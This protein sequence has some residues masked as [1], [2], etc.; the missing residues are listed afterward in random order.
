[1]LDIHTHHPAPQPSGVISLR[2]GV[3]PVD[4]LLPGQAYSAGI[5]PWDSL[6]PPTPEIL[7]ILRETVARPEI[8]A[9]GE[10]GV[11]TVSGGPMFRQ[12][13]L[14]RTHVEVSEEY[15]KPLVIHDVKAHDVVIGLRRDLQPSMPWVIHGFRGKPQVAEM[16]LRA[17]CYLSFG[18][19]FNADTLRMMPADRILAETDE[20]QLSIE[21]II[22]RLSDAAGHDMIALIE[23]NTA[24]FLSGIR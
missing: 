23:S 21:E 2:I 8:V 17:G 14:F 13:Q 6:N 18:E 5:H 1:M 7:D 22:R 20:S 19:R 10:C 9:V 15:R 11:D 12:L 4:A 24:V 16:L 3:D